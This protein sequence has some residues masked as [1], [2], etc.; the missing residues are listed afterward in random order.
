V[1]QPNPQTVTLTNTG[2]AP[3][4]ISSIVSSSPDFVV[5]NGCPVSP[6]TLGPG[7]SGNTCQVS[8][9]STPAAA[10]KASDTL[11]ITDSASGASPTVSMSGTGLTDTKSIAVSP[12]SMVFI[13]QVINTTSTTQSV[14]LTNTGNANITMSSVAVAG[15]YS[16]VSNGCPATYVLTPATSCSIS[17][18]FTPLQAKTL[19]GELTI[20]DTAT[21]ATQKVAL[22][23]TGIATTA[24]IS[25]S[26]TSVA[27][28]QQEVGVPS[29]P[30][31]VY[32]Y[33][34]SNGSV[35]ITSVTPPATDFTV[36]DCTGSIGSL[37]DCT[38]KIVFNP[39][40]TGFRT[41]TIVIIDSVPGGSSPG[42]TINLSGTGVA[43]AAPQA[44]LT[45]A[46]LTFASQALGTTSTAQNINLTNSGESS[47]T[48][49]GITLA[50]ADMGDY[51]QTN[52]C[53]PTLAVSFSCSISVTFKPLATGTRTASVS[54]V[55]SAAGFPQAVTLTG[56]GAAGTTPLVTF[57]PS[58]LT[59]ANVPINTSS[60]S[61][62]ATLPNTGAAVLTI[63]GIAASGTVP[64]DFGQTNTCPVSPATI[65]VN[66]I[67][68]ITV[69]FTPTASIDQTGAITVTDN[70]PNGSD[71]LA[72]AGNGVAPEVNLSATTL[73]FGSQAPS[74]TSAA[75]TVTLENSGSLAL[76][77]TSMAA[78]KDYN[79]VSDTCPSSLAP[80]LT[81]TFGVTFSPTI[82]G[83]ETATS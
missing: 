28:D 56:T 9:T 61:Q 65:A 48:I 71:V 82:T 3:V 5:S 35:S 22:T 57:T 53:P 1:N 44:T 78:T 45:P 49:T 63:T 10:G 64:S 8:V 80:G 40:R 34:Q 4:T 29:Q 19:T 42:R 59:F 25:L 60:T 15:N 11:T 38:I 37:S 55:D 77:I 24:E 6:S 58:T 26:Q 36:T 12:T 73:A 79:I 18:A 23:G 17:V 14:T 54:I 66:G 69:T 72:L 76:S 67:C 50:G 70:T 32:Y 81:C 33:N 46:S 47:M 74:T 21:S 41:G 13:P 39:T 27:F 83:R 7:P 62:T 68:T 20:T 51:V 31:T 2:T 30:Q 75:R 43:A 52:N 16:I